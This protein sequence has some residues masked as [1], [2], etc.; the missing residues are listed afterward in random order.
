VG[1]AIWHIATL[2]TKSSGPKAPSEI[3]D[4]IGPIFYPIDKANIIVDCL[5]KKFGVHDM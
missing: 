1:Q 2:L 3:Y 5:G 4:P